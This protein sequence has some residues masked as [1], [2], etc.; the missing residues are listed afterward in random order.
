MSF[1][2]LSPFLVSYQRSFAKKNLVIG[3]IHLDKSMTEKNPFILSHIA[4]NCDWEN[5]QCQCL[6]APTA[7][8]VYLCTSKSGK[9]QFLLCLSSKEIWF[10]GLVLDQ[11]HSYNFFWRKKKK[12]V[13]SVRLE[14]CLI[15]AQVA[16]GNTELPSLSILPSV[17]YLFEILNP[18]L[19]RL[20]TLKI[21]TGREN[22]HSFVL[23]I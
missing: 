4:D 20:L 21:T 13:F 5:L 22:S 15:K 18:V 8:R 1:S 7:A 19:S 23:S 14:V 6:N 3:V 12:K 10:P 9:M 17:I 11:F 16:F 2:F